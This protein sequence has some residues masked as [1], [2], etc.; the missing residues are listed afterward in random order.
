VIFGRKV[1]TINQ[2]FNM[3][4][5]VCLNP[6]QSCR[7]RTRERFK[8]VETAEIP[9]ASTPAMKKQIGCICNLSA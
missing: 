5:K 2:R 8:N 9:A 1:L 7:R 4:T 6:Y 3:Y